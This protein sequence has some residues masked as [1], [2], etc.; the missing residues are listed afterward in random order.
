MVV[1]VRFAPSPT[2]YL[3]LGGARTALFNFLFARKEKGVF[4]LRIE[5]TD[6]ERSKKEFEEDIKESLLWLGLNWDEGPIRQSERLDL[7]QKVIEELLAKGYAYY[8][9]C[10][11]EELELRRQ[12]QL[13]RGE[14]PKYPGT[15]R[16]LSKEE[17]NER[18]SKK[19]SFVIRLKVPEK[20]ITFKDYLRG[21]IPFDF[22]L[23]GDF[24]IA[25]NFKEPLYLLATPVDDHYQGITHVIR[26]EDH[27]VNT[28]K[29]LLI[30]QYMGWEPPVF[31]HIPLI[32]GQDRSKMSKRHG[33]LNIREYREAGFLPE[34]LLNFLVLLG[35]H[36]GTEKEIISLNE[37]IQKFSLDKIQ[38]RPAVFSPEKLYYFNK[39]YLRQKPN[40]E[41]LEL[42]D[43]SHYGQFTQNGLKAKNGAFYNKEK[44]L[45]IIELGKERAQTLKDILKE[46]EYFFIDFDYQAELLCWQG[47]S[48]EK[49]KELLLK[50]KEAL[51]KLKEE[52]FV[53]NKIQET[54]EKLWVDLKLSNR[55][56]VYWPLRVALSGKEASPPP[57]LLGE[58]FGREFT[59][60]LIEKA[61]EKIK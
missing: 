47:A 24:V 8:C 57:F 6:K 38:K 11:K 37:M 5:D 16:L 52:E 26:G 21:E 10:S 54:L 15:C 34:A 53:S 39:F 35:W 3:H 42:L 43:F 2:G 19:S 41:I 17:V 59:L 12:E 40:E 7:Y 31:V 4:I 23:L 27:I 20:K 28:P 22:R 36:P 51:S 61:L 44:L 30:F 13:A 55:G 1:R 60:K 45:K 46:V 33:A 50:L 58:I 14:T 32:L 49:T 25:R 9:F 29:Q 56:F 18:L 48:L